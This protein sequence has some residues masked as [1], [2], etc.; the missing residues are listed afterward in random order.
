MVY[1]KHLHR[2]GPRERE[3]EREREGGR[4]YRRLRLGKLVF[5][6]SNNSTNLG[7]GAI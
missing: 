4:V 3:R 7:V 6:E 2:E 5:F 1:G